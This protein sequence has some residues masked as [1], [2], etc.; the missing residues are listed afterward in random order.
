M[1]IDFPAGMSLA[2]QLMRVA[3]AKQPGRKHQKRPSVRA[4]NRQAAQAKKA[5]VQRQK[6]DKRKSDSIRSYW[7]GKSEENPAAK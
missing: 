5:R 2:D 7:A 6:L 1:R 3:A 4:K